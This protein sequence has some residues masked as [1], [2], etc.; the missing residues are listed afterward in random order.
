MKCGALVKYKQNKNSKRLVNCYSKSGFLE[1]QYQP[2]EED[3]IICDGDIKCSIDIETD[4]SCSCC[5]SAHIELE[6]KCN[7]CG[8]THFT[9]EGLPILE[10]IQ[11]IIEKQISDISDEDREKLLKINKEKLNTYQQ[12]MF[13]IRSK[14]FDE[15]RKR[16]GKKRS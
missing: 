3:L 14:K 1:Y 13:N 6:Y 7:K 5:S 2:K 10:E 4:G 9:L 16:K 15:A 8:N 12:K 11:L